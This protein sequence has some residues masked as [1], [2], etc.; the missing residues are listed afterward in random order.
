MDDEYTYDEKFE[1][2]IPIIGQTACRKTTFIQK[3]AKNKMFGNLKETYWITKVPLS[4]QR[5]KKLLL[6]FK[7]MLISNIRKL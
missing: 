3:L 1:D 5:E 4:D 2:N 6:V 7:N